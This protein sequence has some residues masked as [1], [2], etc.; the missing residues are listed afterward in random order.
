MTELAAL[1]QRAASLAEGRGRAVLG[2][3]GG[4][5]A[6]KTTLAERLVQALSASPP[7]GLAPDWVAHVPMDGY[8]LADVELARLG[9]LERKGAPDTFDADGYAALLARLRT[10]TGVVVYAPA[11]DRTLEQPVAGSI[12]VPPSVRLV[13]TEGNYLL[14]DQGGWAGVRRHLD[15]VWYCDLTPAERRRRLVQRHIAFGKGE[16]HAVRWVAEVDEPNAQLIEATRGRADLVVL[17]AG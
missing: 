15:E 6:G 10:D 5:G 16:Q 14:L 11:F 17:D 8:H 1:L 7:D 13:I 9:R 2:I 4:P 3:A 12:P